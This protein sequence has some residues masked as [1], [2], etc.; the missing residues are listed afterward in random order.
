ME[1]I[2]I[3]VIKKIYSHSTT[4]GKGLEGVKVWGKKLSFCVIKHKP[5]YV[6]D[7]I[8]CMVKSSNKSKFGRFYRVTQGHL[9]Y[10]I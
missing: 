7:A 9:S 4:L 8:V 3:I 2:C 10:I 5:K 1:D 6:A